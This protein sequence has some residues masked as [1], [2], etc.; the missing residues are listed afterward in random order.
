[1]HYS[2]SGTT[3]VYKPFLFAFQFNKHES[4]IV[5]FMNFIFEHLSIVQK[6]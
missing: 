1:M 5:I 6:L 3:C 4:G 2:S